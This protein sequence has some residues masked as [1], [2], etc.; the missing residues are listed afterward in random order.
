MSWKT[1]KTQRITKH[2]AFEKEVT[3]IDKGG[4]EKVFTISYKIN[5]IDSAGFS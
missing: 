4:N 5:F 3:R 2:F 1:W